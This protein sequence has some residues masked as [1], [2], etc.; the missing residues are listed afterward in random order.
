MKYST[1]GTS[2][3]IKIFLPETE[4]V[5]LGDVLSNNSTS[6]NFF[7]LVYGSTSESAVQL[8]G[9]PKTIFNSLYRWSNK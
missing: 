2:V 3:L 9:L 8:R 7:K 6:I 4:E 5:F 1:I